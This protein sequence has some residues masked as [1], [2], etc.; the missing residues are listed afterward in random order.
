M[1]K[2]NS[3]YS[4]SE[5]LIPY[6]FNYNFYT[7][8]GDGQEAFMVPEGA[9]ELVIQCDTEIWQYSWD[10]TEKIKR[11]EAFIG[12]LHQKSFR[13]KA[14]ES[15]RL[16]S[17]RFK[18]GAFSYFT[19]FPV[20]ELVNRMVNLEDIW[21][22]ED[23]QNFIDQLLHAENH[24]SQMACLEEGL[25]AHY[26]QHAYAYMGLAAIDLSQQ[27]F[28]SVAELS[29]KYNLSK[30]RFREL[31]GKVVGCSPKQFFQ[32]RRINAIIGEYES[33]ISLTQLAM[34]FGYYDQAHFINDFKS[35]T[36]Y[37]P[38]SFSKSQLMHEPAYLV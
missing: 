37:R 22:K 8:E 30:S 31:F 15:G 13:L 9:I 3:T 14:N 20:N 27:P 6:V 26:H 24:Q 10:T 38:S 28:L 35:V 17:I 29:A 21:G 19:P 7:V 33:D 1:I 16:I 32:T 5:D 18:P 25:R 11:Y 36:G 4:P 34:K 12:G 23:S 2:L